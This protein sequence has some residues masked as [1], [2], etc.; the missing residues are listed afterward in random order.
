MQKNSRQWTPTWSLDRFW[1]LRLEL[2][3][4]NYKTFVPNYVYIPSTY[5]NLVVTHVLVVSNLNSNPSKKPLNIQRTWTYPHTRNLCNFES[6]IMWK[7][8]VKLGS[9]HGLVVLGAHVKVSTP[10]NG[11]HSNA[12]FAW[13]SM[14]FILTKVI[15][16]SFSWMSLQIWP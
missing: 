3:C 4:I 10:V 15:F 9:G 1:V 2:R 7:K 8:G 11:C 5:C 6:I 13:T 16:F 14:L 12:N